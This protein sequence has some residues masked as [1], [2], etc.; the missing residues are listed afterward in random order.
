MMLSP[1]MSRWMKP[2]ACRNWTALKIPCVSGAQ[3]RQDGHVVSAHRDSVYEWAQVIAGRSETRRGRACGGLHDTYDTETQ[4][5]LRRLTCAILTLAAL[6]SG[7]VDSTASDSVPSGN[8]GIARPTWSD[9][10]APCPPP[11]SSQHA[12]SAGGC[13]SWIVMTLRCALDPRSRRSTDISRRV[14]TPSACCP[15][16]SHEE[17][18]SSSSSLSSLSSSSSKS[19][20]ASSVPS[21]SYTLSTEP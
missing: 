3:T 7:R 18:S 12:A 15:S 11:S 9:V 4:P 6:P 14:P 8:S 2:L 20:R 5:Q 1:L 21:S 16:P 13:T 17:A 19:F 10:P